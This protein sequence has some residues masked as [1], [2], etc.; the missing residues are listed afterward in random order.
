MPGRRAG[1]IVLRLLVIGAAAMAG[2]WLGAGLCGARLAVLPA[3]RFPFL[4]TP[5]PLPHHV[6]KDPG[7]LALRFAM[8]HDVVHERFPRHGRA[9]YE[10]RDRKTR[11][12]LARLDE[13]DPARFPLLDDLGAGLERLGRSDEAVAV[14]RDKLARQRRLGVAGKE[15]YTSYANLGTFLIHAGFPKALAGDR[16]ALA[17]IEEG[18]SFIRK[19][20][21]VNPDAHFGREAWQAAIAE[22]LAAAMRD[23]KLLRTY[24]CLGNRL[25]LRISEIINRETNWVGTG[26]GRPY[27]AAFAQGKTSEE[28]PAFWRPDVDLESPANWPLVRD[29]RK[30]ITRVGAEDGWDGVPV[31]SHRGPVAFDEPVMGI[32]GM[33]RQGGGANPHFALA[34]GET[35]LRVGERFLAWSAFERASRLAGRYSRDTALQEFLR[36]HCRSR[37][38]EIE[39]TLQSRGGSVSGRSYAYHVDAYLTPAEIG[40]MR[41][42]FEE[43]LAR[44]TE[45]QERMSDFEAAQIAA[46]EIES[47][48]ALLE[49]FERQHGAIATTPGAEETFDRVSKEAKA[50]F[51]RERMKAC[52]FFGACLFASVAIL[53][54][55]RKVRAPGIRPSR[56]DEFS[57]DGRSGIAVTDS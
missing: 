53:A 3:D 37:Q 6:P 39:G 7:G 40:R 1:L 48:E 29:I 22:F 13:A 41:P 19:S 35:M 44:G 51:I 47:G 43:E 18:I 17:G 14:L 28:F 9:Y 31:P 12:R 55:S 45:Y 56:S 26:Y 30:H 52:G 25:D 33:W 4:A 32:I 11:E 16:E 15:L 54:T 5:Y 50:D 49:E 27:D 20:V 57:G 46:G 2:R 8:V 10:W 36:E 42:A 34:L 21:E 24:D 23:P 38:A